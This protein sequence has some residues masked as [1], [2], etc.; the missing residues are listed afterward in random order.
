MSNSTPSTFSC[1]GIPLR[2]PLKH[3][4]STYSVLTC[5][6]QLQAEFPWSASVELPREPA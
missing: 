5:R 1:V 2:G 4:C 6:R 3:S